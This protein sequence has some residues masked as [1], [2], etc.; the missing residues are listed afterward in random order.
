[1]VPP[2]KRETKA[3]PVEQ[4]VMASPEQNQI[5]CPSCG[6]ENPES[7][8]MCQKCRSPFGMA[9]TVKL[10]PPAVSPTPV[11][12]RWSRIFLLGVLALLVATAAAG[13]HYRDR[14]RPTWEKWSQKFLARQEKPGEIG[15]AAASPEIPN[16][17]YREWQTTW[18]NFRRKEFPSLVRHRKFDEA[19]LKLQG[20]QNETKN[21]GENAA[22]AHEK[23]IETLAD[24]N[25]LESLIALCYDRLYEYKKNPAKIVSVTLITGQSYRGSVL[26]V[27]R[28]EQKFELRSAGK[29]KEIAFDDLSTN[30]LAL[31]IENKYGKNG[32]VL[33]YLGLLFRCEDNAKEC[34]KYLEKAA[35]HGHEPARKILTELKGT[36]EIK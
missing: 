28:P 6:F 14:L 27:S 9:P 26:Q 1:M 12:R 18:E 15:P 24:V 22:G 21:F 2:V 20:F 11:K 5:P 31:L 33:H 8:R 30:T 23:I 17:A 3:S 32:K 36:G 4:D 34:Q 10:P 35:Q 29:G 16:Q 13:Y 19:K 25:E 7:S